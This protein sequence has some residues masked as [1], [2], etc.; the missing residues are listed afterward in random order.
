MSYWYWHRY[1]EQHEAEERSRQEWMREVKQ[2]LGIICAGDEHG[3]AELADY[4]GWPKVEEDVTYTVV[5]EHAMASRDGVNFYV[6]PEGMPLIEWWDS[7][8]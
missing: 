3:K 8:P 2:R 6:K 1:A 7:I 4:V 5:S